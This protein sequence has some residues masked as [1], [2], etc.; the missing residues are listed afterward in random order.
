MAD[1]LIAMPKQRENEDEW[2]YPLIGGSISIPLIA[3]DK[4]EKFLLDISR[5]KIDLLRGKH[6]N[7]TR[8][9]IVLARLDFGGSP[10]RNPDGEEIACPHLHLYRENYADKWAFPVPEDKFNKLEDVWHTLQD[11]MRYCNIIKVP[12]IKKGLFI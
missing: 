11:F 1:A 5:G 12:I 8:Q 10:H 9:T 4:R 3:Y 2:E 7:R 6:Q